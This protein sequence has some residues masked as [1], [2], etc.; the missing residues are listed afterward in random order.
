MLNDIRFAGGINFDGSLQGSVIQQGLD[1]PFI[2]FGEASLADP[3]YDTWNETWPHLRGFR[4]QL[5]LK[6]WLHLT[7]SDLPVVFDSAPSAKMLRNETAK[8]LGSLLGLGTL[9]GLRVRT[10]L[11]D[12]ITEA[13]RFFLTGKKPALLRVPSSAYP[14]VMYI[15]T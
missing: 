8:N 13:C 11:T 12:Y 3:G 1:R 10:I 6:D 5:Q 15:R 7:F 9:P 2:N 14:E 4:M